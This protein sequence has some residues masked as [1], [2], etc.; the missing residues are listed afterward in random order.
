M[1]TKMRIISKNFVGDDSCCF[2]IRQHTLTTKT[3]YI[4]RLE[5][6]EEKQCGPCCAEKHFGKTAVANV[7]DL[8]RSAK[9]N[10]SV[11]A[12]NNN[13]GGNSIDNTN[14]NREL[15]YLHLRCVYLLDFNTIPSI[16]YQPLIDIYNKDAFEISDKDKKHITGI[17][18]K[19]KN[20]I[21]SY[22]NLMACYQAKRKINIWMKKEHNNEK[23]LTASNGFYS[24]LKHKGFLKKDQ[25]SG[26]NK[27][28]VK[29]HIP[30]I[31][32]K[33]FF[34]PINYHSNY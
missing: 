15:E 29:I 33:W 27:W 10:E 5:N 21:L 9:K 28:L 6:G 14:I 2:S 18:N 26:I 3:A 12:N 17:M 32:D 22:E 13:K 25:V 7:P 1:V 34:I 20:T 16:Q 19:W 31:D 30:K 4:I 24:Y 11:R 23:A 8:T